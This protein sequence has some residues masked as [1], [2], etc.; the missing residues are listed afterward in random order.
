M[1]LVRK[2]RIEIG[3]P[4]SHTIG[5][6]ERRK[7]VGVAADE[8]GIGHHPPAVGKTH[9]ALVSYGADRADKVLIGPHPPGDAV[10]DDAEPLN[11]HDTQSLYASVGSLTRVWRPN[12]QIRNCRDGN[13]SAL[14][15]NG[16]ELHHVANIQPVIA[17]SFL[18]SW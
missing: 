16:G 14:D 15:D 2:R 4:A 9:A 12:A 3:A 5:G 6:R 10:H 18:R 13:P 11:G 7:F 17:S 1:G 8:D